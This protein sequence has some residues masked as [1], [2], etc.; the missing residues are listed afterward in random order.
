MRWAVGSDSNFFSFS[1]HHTRQKVASFKYRVVCIRL[2]WL[3]IKCIVFIAGLADQGAFVM[4][5]PN[6]LCGKLSENV[7]L[8]E[9]QKVRINFPIWSF[10]CNYAQSFPK[11]VSSSLDGGL[12]CRTHTL[13]RPTV[14]LA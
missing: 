5:S 6:L 3:Q 1:L 8:T 14:F 13:H 10:L 12:A 4:M 7:Q 11:L 2:L 9:Q